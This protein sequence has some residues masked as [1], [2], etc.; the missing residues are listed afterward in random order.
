MLYKQIFKTW[1][2]AVKRATFERHHVKD[3]SRGNVNY[4]FFVV[5]CLKNGVPDAAPYDNAYANNPGYTYR[6][7]KT[8]DN[9][10]TPVWRLEAQHYNNNKGI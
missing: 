5:R 1:D 6:I 9:E 8:L 7:E 4:R 2:G 3:G 10:A